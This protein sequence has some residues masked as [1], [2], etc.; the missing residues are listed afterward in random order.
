MASGATDIVTESLNETSMT[1]AQK[2]AYKKC[3]MQFNACRV[4]PGANMS[5]CSSK[6]VACFEEVKEE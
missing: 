6:A 5:T 4:A 1:A 3:Q 2:Q